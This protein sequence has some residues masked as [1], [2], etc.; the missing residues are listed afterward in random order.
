[1][2]TARHS[3]TL[4]VSVPTGRTAEAMKPQIITLAN[5]IIAKLP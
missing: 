4:Q 2:W 1:V 3:L 5:A